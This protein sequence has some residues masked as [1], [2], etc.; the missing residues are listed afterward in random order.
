VD[1]YYDAVLAVERSWVADGPCSIS[2]ESAYWR[3]SAVDAGSRRRLCRRRITGSRQT[4]VGQS[5]LLARST[6][7]WSACATKTLVPNPGNFLQC[8]RTSSTTW[9]FPEF[10]G[11]LLAV[12]NSVILMDQWWL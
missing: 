6:D 5:R 7:R 3:C 8:Q 12:M 10:G 11:N 9:L 4:T 1:D 2:M